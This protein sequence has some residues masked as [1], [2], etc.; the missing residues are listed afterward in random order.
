[1]DLKDSFTLICVRHIYHD[2]SVKT[3]RTEKCGVK[4]VNTVCS[5]HN[6]NV[7]INIETVH[8]Y[9]DLVQCLLTLILSAAKA[10]ASLTADCID[11]IDEYYGRSFLLG[12]GEE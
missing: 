10:C 4:N 1:M 3:P 2:T 5:S 12:I 6:D 7:G 8:L 11:L 9:K